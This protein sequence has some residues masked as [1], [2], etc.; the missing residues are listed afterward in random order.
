M[1]R[2]Y[3]GLDGIIWATHRRR[4][5]WCW[6]RTVLSDFHLVWSS[7]PGCRLR[8]RPHFLAGQR[9]YLTSRPDPRLAAALGSTAQIIAFAAVGAPLSYVGASLNLP[10]HDHWFDL[11]DRALGLD[12][13]GAARL[14]RTPM[15]PFI[16][17]FRMIYLSLMPQTLVVVLALAFAGRL[18]SAAG[19]RCSPFVFAA[20]GDDRHRGGRSRR[21]GRLGLLQAAR[22][23][24]PGHQSR[25]AATK[26]LPIFLGLRD[27]SFRLLMARG[28]DGII[29][30]PQPA[31]GAGGNHDRRRAVAAAGAALDRPR[32]SIQ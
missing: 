11:A 5:G 17:V 22:R 15:R 28:S 1:Q 21:E 8:Q 32:R 20:P 30:F 27:G 25:N 9:F 19:I 26:H 12:W 24:L 3:A 14:D 2:D 10:L 4:G 13:S 16:R 18:G 6:P 7:V 23:R 29:A 31:C